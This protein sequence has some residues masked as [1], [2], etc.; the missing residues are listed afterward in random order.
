MNTQITRWNPFREMDE[1]QNRMASILNWDALRPTTGKE[2]TLTVADW[3]PRVDIVEDEK[4]YVVKAELP[5]MKKEDVKVTVEDGVL[6]ISGD[7]KLAKEEKNQRFHRIEREYGS[8]VRSF[9]LP[10]GTSGEKVAAE[11]KD[12][13]LKIRLPKDAKSPTK[14]IDIKIG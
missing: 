10:P 14:A 11:F 7:R 9:T 13:V 6:T 3:S 4:E 2:E 1:I 12:G 8:F 5:E